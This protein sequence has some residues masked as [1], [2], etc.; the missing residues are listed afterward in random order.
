MYKVEQN[1][2]PP[3]RPFVRIGT[4]SGSEP[5]PVIVIIL[6]AH[7]GWNGQFTWSGLNI[8]SLRVLQMTGYGSFKDD[9]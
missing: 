6:C 1:L 3:N 7:P 8:L 9:F 4:I 2:A 5:N